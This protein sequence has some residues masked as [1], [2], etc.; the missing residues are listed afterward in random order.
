MLAAN[1]QAAVD[2]ALAERPLKYLDRI[3]VASVPLS[4]WLAN[5]AYWIAFP[6]KPAKIEAGDAA[7][8]QA[9]LDMHAAIVFAL[10]AESPQAYDPALPRWPLA[11]PP[12]AWG[13]GAAFGAR[14]PARKSKPQTRY[15]CGVDLDADKGVPVLSPE[16]ATV[17]AVD[18]GW[19]NPTKAIILHLDSGDTLLLG[20]LRKGMLVAPGERVEQGQPVAEVEAYPL[21]DTMVHVQLYSGDRSKSFVQQHMS[22]SLGSPQPA[23]LLDPTK[24]LQ[25]AAENTPNAAA[26]TFVGAFGSD[27]VDPRYDSAEE[28][29]GA[30]GEGGGALVAVAVGL[31][32]AVAAGAGAAYLATRDDPAPRRRLR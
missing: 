17:V 8:G 28:A 23:G 24:Y 20:G 14:R 16:G 6:D 21:G 1:L 12:R 13:S 2:Q 10:L 4:K 26:D 27:S 31:A 5:V 30:D 32:L 22:W 11:T 7:G 18:V 3:R 15:H 29:E 19:E 9:W 25:R